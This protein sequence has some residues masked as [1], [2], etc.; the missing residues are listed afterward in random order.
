[1]MGFWLPKMA[2]DADSLFCLRCL[3]EAVVRFQP[4]NSRFTT[5]FQI[6]HQVNSKLLASLLID[7]IITKVLR[8]FE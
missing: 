7:L 2:D 6:N 1:M 5:L 3:F 4:Q 8:G